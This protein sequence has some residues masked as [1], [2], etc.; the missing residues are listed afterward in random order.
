V[1]GTYVMSRDETNALECAICT[2][3]FSLPIRQCPNGH[4]FCEECIATW[5][6]RHSV[7][8]TCRCEVQLE[9]MTRNRAMESLLEQLHVSTH[10]T[11][12]H[13]NS[14]DGKWA[15]TDPEKMAEVTM[16]PLIGS[17]QRMAEQTKLREALQN[18]PNSNG[19]NAFIF[20]AACFLVIAFIV[21]FLFVT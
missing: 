14:S 7:C 21:S 17:Y 16:L 4:S 5:C 6:A 8:P 2:S 10:T 13:A 11:A 12:Q 18:A 20:N 9:S 1:P 3:E 19:R 15:A